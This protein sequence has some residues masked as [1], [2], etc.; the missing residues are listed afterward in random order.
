MSQHLPYLRAWPFYPLMHNPLLAVYG[1]SAVDRP[2]RAAMAGFAGGAIIGYVIARRASGDRAAM[3]LRDHPKWQAVRD[4]LVRDH[5]SRSFLKTVSMIALFRMPPNSPFALTNLEMASV[6]VP[7]CPVRARH[8]D[9]HAPRTAT[10]VWIGSA[11]MSKE[12]KVPDALVGHHQW[13]RRGVRVYLYSSCGS[14][15]AP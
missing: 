15:T 14:P 2:R 12:G 3:L 4:A 1:L 10:A 7:H 9:R 5:E 8:S 6:K 13:L 11:G